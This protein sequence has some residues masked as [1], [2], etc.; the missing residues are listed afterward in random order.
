M[1]WLPATPPSTIAA[2]QTVTVAHPALGDAKPYGVDA[3]AWSLSPGQHILIL[4]QATNGDWSC[5]S[6]GGPAEIVDPDPVAAV[7]AILRRDAEHMRAVAAD[8]A[9]ALERLQRLIADPAG[10]SP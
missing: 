6:S 10:V 9:A 3:V 2:A 4:G 5:V 7:T 1:S 8:M